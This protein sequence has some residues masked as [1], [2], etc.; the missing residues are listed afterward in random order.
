MLFWVVLM[1]FALPLIKYLFSLRT[2]K[3][4][5]QRQL[6]KIQQRLKEIEERNKKKT[7]L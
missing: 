1:V 3:K 2:D 7:G 6:M 4:Q 5:D